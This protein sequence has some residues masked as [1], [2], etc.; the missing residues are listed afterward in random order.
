[1]LRK[2]G[3]TAA[4]SNVPPSSLRSRTLLAKTQRSTAKLRRP[5][6]SH[7]VPPVSEGIVASALVN[8][9]P[10]VETVL[11]RDT[12]RRARGR[13]R[14]QR[15]HGAAAAAKVTALSFLETNTV[16]PGTYKQ[17]SRV[18]ALFQR[19]ARRN[20][21]SLGNTDAALVQFLEY[22][23]F[24][25]AISSEGSAVL[26]AREY[27]D[28]SLVDCLPKARRALK[29]FARLSPGASRAPL[30]LIGLFCLVGAALSKGATMRGLA[31]LLCFHSYLRPT[32]LATLK[33]AQLIPPASGKTTWGV[34]LAPSEEQI[35]SKTGQL[36]ESVLMD[37]D[38][39]PGI[40]R[41][42]QRRLEGLG[43]A[44]PLWPVEQDELM[45]TFRGDVNCS[46]VHVRN[47][48]F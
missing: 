37:W 32:E 31:Y 13:V 35:G 23:Y 48:R 11:H 36:D 25:G 18:R 10:M 7:G 8:A 24:D 47:P 9:L 30:P 45:A 1:M 26:A 20:K 3:G 38:E 4:P 17:Y 14:L 46:G 28:L 44:E 12:N 16:R 42:L 27:F 43:P 29:G 34:L 2:R 33:A 39:V 19:W 22:L 41:A 5:S 21:V 40:G 6:E 15:H